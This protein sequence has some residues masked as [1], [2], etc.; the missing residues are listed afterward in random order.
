MTRHKGRGLKQAKQIQE[1]KHTFNCKRDNL[2]VVDIMLLPKLDG[3]ILQVSN[4]RD[5]RM[6][7]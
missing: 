5:H 7:K 2:T 3:T 1:I 6:W 4:R